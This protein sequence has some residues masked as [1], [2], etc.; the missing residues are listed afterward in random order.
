MESNGKKIDLRKWV[1]E[2]LLIEEDPAEATHRRNEQA[3]DAKV[4][5]R[6]EEADAV[7]RR[8]RETFRLALMAIIAVAL[9]YGA[10]ALMTSPTASADDRRW[11]TAAL[12][13][14]LTGVL[15]FLA[16]KPGG[17]R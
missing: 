4:R 10:F 16:G 11:S 7:H 6:I 5:R 1:P 3:E 2:D 13:S 15:G 17:P 12:G 14:I 8:Y 9:A